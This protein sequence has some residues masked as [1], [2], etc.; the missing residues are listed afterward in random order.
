MALVCLLALTPAVVFAQAFVVGDIRVEGL[1]RVSTGT[2]FNELPIA[3]GDSITEEDTAA[4]LRS[5]F[6][7]GF[8]DDVRIE[9][10]GDTL[11]VVVVERPSIASID[12]T[13]NEAVETEQLVESLGRVGFAVGRT[14]DPVVLN[15]MVQELRETYFAQGRYSSEIEATVTPLPRHRVGIHFEI[16][17][18]EV[19]RIR[20]INIVGNR[21]FDE[22]DLLDE[23]ESTTRTLFSWLTR[24]D[25]YS[26]QT[27]AGDLER[28]RTYYLDRGFI[29]FAIDSTLV[30]LTPEKRNIYITINVTEGTTFEVGTVELAGDLVVAPEEL[31]PL[32]D[33]RQGDVFNRSDVVST[34]T[35]V[36]TRLGDEGY[37]FANVNAVLRRIR[38]DAGLVDLAFFVDPGQRVYVRR[39][40]FRGNHQTRDE[41]LRR[42]M[43]QLEGSWVVNRDLNRIAA[44]PAPARTLRRSPDRDSAGSG[45]FRPGGRDCQRHG[46][47]VRS[48][49]PQCG[50]R[51]GPWGAIQHQRHPGESVRDRQLRF[52]HVQQQQQPG[53]GTRSRTPIRTSRRRESAG[54]Y[55]RDTRRPK[56]GSS[57]SRTTRPTRREPESAIGIPD[58]RVRP[59]PRRDLRRGDR[60]RGR[61]PMHPGR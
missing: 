13:G 38:E 10:D 35:S 8:F 21:S 56:G 61:V 34:A 59:V 3:V 46:A 2:V 11:V 52:L 32:V 28:L 50:L 42:E 39:I 60:L 20:R 54:G 26:K 51:A 58:Q 22:E 30:S 44:A 43:R 55:S 17:E 1:R 9:R 12:F 29:N 40:E 15:Q 19:A 37:A 4:A 47:S 14:F 49:A 53:G 7:T 48:A 33:V 27:L 25:R 36:K 16:D 6:A 5:L 24:S 57:T 23:F 18:G 45:N 31:I 41:V